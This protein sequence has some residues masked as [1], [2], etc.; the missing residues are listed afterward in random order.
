MG[1]LECV[2]RRHPGGAA[3]R[4]VSSATPRIGSSGGS[5]PSWRSKVAEVD[6]AVICT[7]AQTGIGVVDARD[8]CTAKIRAGEGRP[9]R[10]VRGMGGIKWRA[11]RVAG[12]FD[13]EHGE[14]GG[15]SSRLRGPLSRRFSK[16]TNMRLIILAAFFGCFRYDNLKS[17]VKRMPRPGTGTNHALY[18]LPLALA[19]RE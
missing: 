2:H 18:R 1:P 10:L 11:D 13:A 12:L 15:L 14:R 4:R 6:C 5:E 16:P 3:V 9:G 7:G 19:F 17:A 8:L